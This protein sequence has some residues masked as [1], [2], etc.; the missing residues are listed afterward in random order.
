MVLTAW[1]SLEG[2]FDL[3]ISSK[4]KRTFALPVSASKVRSLLIYFFLGILSC[5]LSNLSA[6]FSAFFNGFSSS[7][8]A[9]SSSVKVSC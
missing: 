2:G 8:S 9:R 6:A 4:Y 5:A 1:D 3:S 7:G